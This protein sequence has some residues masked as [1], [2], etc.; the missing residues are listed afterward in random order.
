MSLVHQ[1]TIPIGLRAKRVM[2]HSVIAASAE[3]NR[4]EL[5][6]LFSVVTGW[7]LAK[8]FAVLPISNLGGEVHPRVP[9]LHF[10]F[11]MQSTEKKQNSLMSAGER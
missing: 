6:R 1:M 9:R 8:E 5:K 7:A 10:H 2:A 4:L 11:V 3:T